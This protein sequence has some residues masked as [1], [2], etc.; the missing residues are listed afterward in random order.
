MQKV[1]FDT[2]VI[3]NDGFN[4]FLGNRNELEKFAKLS[5][6]IIPDMVIEEIKE[7]KLRELK[8]K[9]SSFKDNPF[10]KLYKLNNDKTKFD[11]EKIIE[12]LQ[13]QESIRYEI[14]ELNDYSILKDI[15][16][17]ALK[18]KPPFEGKSDTDKGFKDAYIFYTILEYKKT[19]NNEN[20]Y[21]VG[22]DIKM[23]EALNNEER[24]FVIENYDEFLKHNLDSIC[25]EYFYKKLEDE[26]EFKIYRENIKDL[27]LN[28][29]ENYLVLIEKD[30]VKYYI[31]IDS[32]EI[33]SFEEEQT[34]TKFINDFIS[35]NDIYKTEEAT[36]NLMTYISLLDDINIIKILEASTKNE[37]IFRALSTENVK[38]LLALLFDNKKEILDV[39][40]QIKIR[41]LLAGV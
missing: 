34:F 28:I 22:K 7:Q 33:V 17:L 38:Q 36:D 9:A 12:D 13:T 14:I 1:I 25:D 10:F 16:N 23:K 40:L 3:K 27:S 41:E 24:V 15:K 18:K 19:L 37:S 20:I 29:N 35:S 30:K 32:G 8:S 2:N 26:Y 39:E 6:I 11:Y 5:E 21:F 31:E 4:N